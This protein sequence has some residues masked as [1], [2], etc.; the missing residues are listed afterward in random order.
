MSARGVRTSGSASLWRRSSSRARLGSDV[1]LAITP[2]RAR[3]SSS[4][5]S[6][7]SI[8]GMAYFAPPMFD[9]AFGTCERPMT[10]DLS[11]AGRW[12]LRPPRSIC[13]MP[14]RT[15]CAS[16][17]GIDLAEFWKMFRLDMRD[18]RSVIVPATR[19]LGA[20]D[21]STRLM[22]HAGEAGH[23]VG[24]GIDLG[25]THDLVAAR[26]F[27]GLILENGVPGHH[28]A[29]ACPPAAEPPP[30]ALLC[31]YCCIC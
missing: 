7:T 27:L 17:V 22:N 20:D 29:F 8:L 1:I 31:R 4:S 23:L 2:L 15:I 19:T 26:H 9:P 5:F 14:T 6:S 24:V 18:L 25:G 21:A 30:A 3:A 10:S 28:A 13:S 12:L 16:L 11:C